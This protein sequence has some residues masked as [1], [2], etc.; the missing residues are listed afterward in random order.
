M[1]EGTGKKGD[2]HLRTIRAA[3]GHSGWKVSGSGRSEEGAWW[4]VVWE[5]KRRN[6]LDLSPSRVIRQHSQNIKH[7]RMLV[8]K[9][10]SGKK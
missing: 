9:K 3:E 8:E 10:E 5:A 1:I 4:L 2:Q 7:R 6:K